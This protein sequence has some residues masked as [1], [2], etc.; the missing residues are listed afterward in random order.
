MCVCVCACHVAVHV[1]S[2][3]ILNTYIYIY[4]YAL[5][6]EVVTVA[7]RDTSRQHNNMIDL[8]FHGRELKDNNGKAKPTMGLCVSQFIHI[9]QVW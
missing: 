9:L 6:W 8:G 1:C 7:I 3:R 4:V 5:Q 2:M